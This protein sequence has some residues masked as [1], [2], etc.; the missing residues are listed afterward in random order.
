MT[1]VLNWCHYRESCQLRVYLGIALKL[2]F[3]KLF[4]CLF[5]YFNTFLF[6]WKKKKTAFF[7]ILGIGNWL[8]AVLC[9]VWPN[10]FH[11]FPMPLVHFSSFFF[12]LSTDAEL[13]IRN[14]CVFYCH[15]FFIIL[16]LFIQNPNCR[17]LNKSLFS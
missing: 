1:S 15:I 12:S 16:N 7:F 3:L 4:H 10:S 6:F 13:T 8:K 14:F 11:F 17:P 2:S 9:A 5:R